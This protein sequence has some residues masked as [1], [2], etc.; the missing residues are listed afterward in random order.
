MFL[1]FSP[2]ERLAI[3]FRMPKRPQDECRLQRK[4]QEVQK[5]WPWNDLLMLVEV[6][7]GW[8]DCDQQ[9]DDAPRCPS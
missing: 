9:S 7:V 4:P 3:A 1:G 8:K 6:N 2:S 5:R